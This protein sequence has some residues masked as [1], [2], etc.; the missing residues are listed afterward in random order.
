MIKYKTGSLSSEIY[1]LVEKTDMF[2]NRQLQ[3]NVMQWAYIQEKPNLAGEQGMKAFPKMTFVLKD[4][5]TKNIYSHQEK[6]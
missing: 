4:E 5:L 3:Y 1:P 2:V 6:E